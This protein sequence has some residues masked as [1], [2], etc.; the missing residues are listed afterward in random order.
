MKIMAESSITVVRIKNFISQFSR[1][2]Q[3]KNGE[4]VDDR[5]YFEGNSWICIFKSLED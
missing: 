5:L 2:S 1:I 3:E 4:R